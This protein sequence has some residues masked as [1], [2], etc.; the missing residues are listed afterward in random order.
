MA[1]KLIL[2]DAEEH[3]FS[4]KKMIV[5][6]SK[7]E[8]CFLIYHSEKIMLLVLR[9]CYWRWSEKVI[10]FKEFDNPL[11]TLM[12]PGKCDCACLSIECVLN[13]LQVYKVYKV[14]LHCSNSYIYF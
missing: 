6:C 2:L 12:Y 10:G 8:K 9:T 5:S 11:D 4:K 14:F 7:T 1:E 13:V 3:F